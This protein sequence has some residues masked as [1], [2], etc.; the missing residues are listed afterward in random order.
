[1]V[2]LLAQMHC[3]RWDVA[4]QCEIGTFQ[5]QRTLCQ[6]HLPQLLQQQQLL[7]WNVSDAAK[8]LRV[9]TTLL[10]VPQPLQTVS[11]S[12]YQLV[13]HKQL[14]LLQLQAG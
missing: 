1:M 8:F 11:Q 14:T 9:V 5:K 4:L 2:G 6:A 13:L 10:S 3:M 12:R 7:D